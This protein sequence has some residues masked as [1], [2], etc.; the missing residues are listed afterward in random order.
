MEDLPDDAVQKVLD[1]AEGTTRKTVPEVQKPKPR[2]R[3]TG[4][5]L[6]QKE[7]RVPLMKALHELGGKAST[8]QLRPIMGERMK[9][10]LRDPDYELV[11]TGEPRWWNAIC[12]ERNDLVKE[13]LFRR[14]SER[15]IWELS[16]KGVQFI[17]STGS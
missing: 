3:R 12:W 9:A 1:A 8:R 11:A 2:S 16:E 6:P 15:G 14:D 17:E 7:F 13:G 10:K 4:D 5:K